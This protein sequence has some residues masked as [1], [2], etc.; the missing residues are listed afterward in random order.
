V[1]L[2]DGIWLPD[3]D[4][5]FARMMRKEPQRAYKGRSVGCYQYFK[6]EKALAL[7]ERRG[8]A[9]DVGAHVGFW[10]MWLALHFQEVHAF[11][12]VPEHVECFKKNVK[13]LVDIHE[14]AVG[15]VKSLVCINRHP[16]NSGKASIGDGADFVDVRSID[17]YQFEDVALIKIDVEGYESEVLMGAAKSI[18]RCKPLVILEDN[19]QHERYGLDSPRLVA[20]ELGLKEVGQMGKDWIYV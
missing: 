12:P 17:S 9:L 14:H 5:H 20:E 1:K 10:S 19:G 11:E 7:T 13:D 8:V 18:A 2:V 4:T 15:A 6:I 16:D 3:S